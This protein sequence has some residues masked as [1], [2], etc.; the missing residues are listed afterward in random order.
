[1]SVFIAQP[2]SVGS[3]GVSS[4]SPSPC[5]EEVVV[6]SGESPTRSSQPVTTQSQVIVVDSSLDKMPVGEGPDSD[7]EPRRQASQ[8]RPIAGHVVVEDPEEEADDAPPYASYGE[9]DESQP[10]LHATESFKGSSLS[11]K[12]DNNAGACCCCIC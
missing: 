4:W 8:P 11:N 7:E 3:P 9:A 1:M 5:T 2:M 6:T 10:L 12:G